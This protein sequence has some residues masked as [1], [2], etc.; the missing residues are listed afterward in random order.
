[1][2][3]GREDFIANEQKRDDEKRERRKNDV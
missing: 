3:Q 1:M 2:A